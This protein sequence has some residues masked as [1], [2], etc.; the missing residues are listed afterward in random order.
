VAILLVLA[1]K[2][3]GYLGMDY[4]LLR[5]L[6]VPWKGSSAHEGT[7][8]GQIAHDFGLKPAAMANERVKV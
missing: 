6:G 8:P 1:W 5:W 3:A 2:T 4:I 7:V